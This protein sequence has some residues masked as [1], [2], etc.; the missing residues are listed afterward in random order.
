M[1]EDFLGSQVDV[2][3]RILRG[4]NS[5]CESLGETEIA[6]CKMTYALS[7]GHSHVNLRVLQR[8]KRLAN[9]FTLI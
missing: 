9:I 2:A 5:H 4:S 8:L 1:L 3:P 6:S 7:C